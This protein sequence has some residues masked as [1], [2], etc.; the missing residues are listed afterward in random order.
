MHLDAS[1]EGL[2]CCPN[3]MVYTIPLPRNFMGYNI[4]Q[5]EMVNVV[6]ALKVWNHLWT[7]KHIEFFVTTDQL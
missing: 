3:N 7:N 4:A 6:V 1:L 5:L 2:G